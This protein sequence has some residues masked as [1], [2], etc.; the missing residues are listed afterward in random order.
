LWVL[1]AVA[2]TGDGTFHVP[3]IKYT[4]YAC[5]THTASNTAMRGFGQP[6]AIFIMEYAMDKLA[7]KAGILPEKVKI[8]EFIFKN[9]PLPRW[10]SFFGEGGI[11]FSLKLFRCAS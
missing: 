1:G 4:A 6:Q 7:R 8:P 9:D 11:I 3:N 10:S 5:K 2:S